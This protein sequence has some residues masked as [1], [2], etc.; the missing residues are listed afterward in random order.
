MTHIINNIH[1]GNRL[2]AKSSYFSH[3]I[4]VTKDVRR[5]RVHAGLG[6]SRYLRIAINDTLDADLLRYLKQVFKFIDGAGDRPLLIY[7]EMGISRSSSI[8]IAYLIYKHRWTIDKALHYVQ[9]RRP[10]IWPNKN[11]MHQLRIF[12]QM[13]HKY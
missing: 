4:N 3:Y 2:D 8:V 11:F 7:C 1:L 13:V 5:E 6:S 12:H 9:A 10:I